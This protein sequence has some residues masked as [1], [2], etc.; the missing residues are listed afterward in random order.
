MVLLGC[1]A[2]QASHWLAD[3]SAPA[4]VHADKVTGGQ[5]SSRLLNMSNLEHP[6]RIIMHTSLAGGSEDFAKI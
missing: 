3:T 4:A 6:A 5:M 1:L 2:W